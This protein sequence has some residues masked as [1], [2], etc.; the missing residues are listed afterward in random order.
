MARGSLEAYVMDKLQYDVKG[1]ED[2]DETGNAF[3][4]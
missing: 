1:F 3:N 2:I 4:C